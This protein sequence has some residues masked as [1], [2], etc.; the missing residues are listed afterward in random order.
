LDRTQALHPK[1]FFDWATT[2]AAATHFVSCHATKILAT[3]IAT[4]IQ[5]HKRTN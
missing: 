5:S 2:A 1:V 4:I 3:M